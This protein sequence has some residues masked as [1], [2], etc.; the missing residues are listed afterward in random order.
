MPA[1]NFTLQEENSDQHPSLSTQVENMQISRNVSTGF[2]CPFTG[3]KKCCKKL[4]FILKMY[5]SRV[6]QLLV[7]VSLHG[8]RDLP[9]LLC[10]IGAS[11][12][13]KLKSNANWKLL[14]STLQFPIFFPEVLKAILL[15][16]SFQILKRLS[17][18]FNSTQSILGQK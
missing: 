2:P 11:I 9:S 16:L 6:T 7:N 14:T 12:V 5:L 3:G 1:K 13:Q 10:F 18:L 17:L 8:D 4:C 15:T